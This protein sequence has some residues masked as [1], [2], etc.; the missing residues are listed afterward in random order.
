MKLIFVGLKHFVSLDQFHHGPIGMYNGGLLK[1]ILV[2]ES[3][4]SLPICLLWSCSNDT[5]CMNSIKIS[6][7]DPRG[8]L[9][10]L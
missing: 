6:F 4:S 1:L 10:G 5:R 9:K 7:I 2:G 3:C 8:G